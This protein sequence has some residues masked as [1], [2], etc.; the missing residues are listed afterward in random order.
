[1]FTEDEA[2]NER[3]PNYVPVASIDATVT[4]VAWSPVDLETWQQLVS[5]RPILQF[6]DMEHK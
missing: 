4:Q 1:M 6:L 2:I 5:A 3:D